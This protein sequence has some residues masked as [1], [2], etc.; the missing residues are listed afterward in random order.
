LI[1]SQLFLDLGIAR[2]TPTH[3]LNAAQ[4]A[5]L[6]HAIGGEKLEFGGQLAE[7][8]T[9]K[10]TGVAFAPGQV[11]NPAKPCVGASPVI[12]AAVLP[13]QPLAASRRISSALA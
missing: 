3:D 10:L 7:H 11:R 8:I 4:I 6:A 1:S 9:M 2:L 5:Q 12:E 13:E